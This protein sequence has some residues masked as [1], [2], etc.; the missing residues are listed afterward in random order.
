[1]W[2]KAPVSPVKNNIQGIQGTNISHLDKR[3]IIFKHAL[4]GDM[5][6][7]SKVGFCLFNPAVYRERLVKDAFRGRWSTSPWMD[8]R[9][10]L[11]EFIRLTNCSNGPTSEQL[12]L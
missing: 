2:F 8:S 6:V 9:H 10:D 4:G 7:P 3:K 11:G 1:M 12:A 5:F